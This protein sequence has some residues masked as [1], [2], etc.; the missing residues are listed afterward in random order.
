MQSVGV[1]LEREATF[2]LAHA[3]L[4]YSDGRR[5]FVA[6]HD[7]VAVPGA[8]PTLGPGRIVSTAFLRAMS[9]Q[10]GE[11]VAPD[12]LPPTVLVRTSDVTLWW[13]P[14]SIETL[15]YNPAKDAAHAAALNALNGKRVPIP[16]LVF[17]ATKQQLWVRALAKN[18]RPTAS[19]PLFAAPF[20]NVSAHGGVCLGSMRRP[21][22]RGLE[23]L[24][25]WERG[26][27]ESEFTHILPGVVALAAPKKFDG[28]TG[29]WS[30][31]ARRVAQGARGADTFPTAWLAPAPKK[32]TLAGFVASN[33]IGRL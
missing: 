28:F 15:F 23:T 30:E 13:R 16:P 21:Q 14:A 17:R 10:L 20:F 27:F 22:G 32:Q 3:L 29:A 5:S 25:Q 24:P 6:L 18:E 12:V 26:F 8:A 7:P 2:G 19:T 1:S 9:K 11:S 31:L 4:V 33:T